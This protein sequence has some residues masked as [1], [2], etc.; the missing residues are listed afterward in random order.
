MPR[1]EIFAM[2]EE[3]E[4][5]NR[6]CVECGKITGN[7]CEGLS[8]AR[9]DPCTAARRM[10]SQIWADGQRVPMCSTCEDQ[11]KFCKF[12][13]SP[14]VRGCV[15]CGLR[16]GNWCGG[17]WSAFRGCPADLHVP[18]EIWEVG[19]MTPLCTKCEDRWMFCRFCRGVSSC[20]PPDREMPQE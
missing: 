1:M 11:L 2:A 9:G 17:R 4:M 8:G 13:R 5:L 6:P 7:F 14:P 19:Q 16:T 3:V 15:D 10:P 18:K 20:T 12:C